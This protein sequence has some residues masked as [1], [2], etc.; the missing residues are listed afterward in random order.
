MSTGGSYVFVE[1]VS[2]SVQL[3]ETS[4]LGIFN[5]KPEVSSTHA[6]P[7]CQINRDGVGFDNF[8]HTGHIIRSDINQFFMC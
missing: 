1:G 7:H 5:L 6:V 8:L 3:V 2:E 4:Q